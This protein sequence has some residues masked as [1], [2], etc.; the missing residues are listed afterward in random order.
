LRFA[1]PG[2]ASKRPVEIQGLVEDTLR[3]ILPEA[4]R[5][6]VAVSSHLPDGAARVE[7]DHS[8]L[9]QAL[10]NLLINAL[11]AMPDGGRLNVTSRVSSAGEV[12]I[13]IAD[14]GAGI[15]PEDLPKL[16]D[17]YFTTKVRGFGLGLT[18]VERI[19]QEHGGT[20]EVA[21]ELGSGATFT[22]KLPVY[23]VAENVA[24]CTT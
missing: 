15:A 14:T 21:S 24:L 12:E 2:I 16:F 20:V 13:A 3:F 19:I 9:R 7:G 22:I 5:S 18:I 11:Q 8:Q 23:R 10:L 4:E 17:P 6:G 1:K